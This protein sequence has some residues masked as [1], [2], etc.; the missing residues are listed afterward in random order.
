MPQ[1]SE[2]TPFTVHRSGVS[3]SGEATG[4]GRALV[5]LHGLTATRR[6]VVHGSKRL[7]RAGYRVVAY[8]ARGHGA[9]AGPVDPAAYEY[10]DLVADLCAVLDAE[11]AGPVVLVG[12]SM[13]AHTAVALSVEQPERVAALVLITPA[14][15]VPQSSPPELAAWDAL[16]NGLSKGGVEGFIE[17]WDPKVSDEWVETARRIARQR[18]SEHRD[19]HA[20][21]QAL[22]VVPRSTPFSGLDE[23][24]GL[25]RPTLV[26]GSRDEA[27]PAHPLA[28]AQAYAEQL[29]NAELLVED[30]GE[31]PLAWQ[32]GRLSRAIEA[33]LARAL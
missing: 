8:D 6:Y 28:V 9:S 21:A 16:A 17:A 26:V 12:A 13:G 7:Q 15:T 4:S 2:T 23:L 3:L 29:P 22:R 25:E 5:L 14:Y 24:E 11:V 32:G 27:D 33:F 20:V 30:A 31:S 10:G 19:L 1:A 18:L